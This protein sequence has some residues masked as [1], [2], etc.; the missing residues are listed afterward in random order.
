MP[1]SRIAVYP[2]SFDPITSGHLDLIKRATKLFDHVIVLVANNA[3]KSYTFTAAERVDMIESCIRDNPRADVEVW[4]GLVVDFL[5]EKGARILIRG[6]RVVSDVDYEF[7]MASM[8]RQLHPDVETV[9]L[10]PDERFTYLSSTVIKEV[11][12]MGAHVDEYLP[13]PVVGALQKKFKLKK[14]KKR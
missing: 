4:D 12:R 11:T 13:A 6:L 9:F 5:K 7:M 8:N 10:M 2:G 3:S 14:R 1:Q